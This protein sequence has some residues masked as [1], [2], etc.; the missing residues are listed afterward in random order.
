MRSE[1]EI[2]QKVDGLIAAEIR[3][4]RSERLSKGH[5]NCAFNTR[6]R[7]NKVGPTGF[8]QNKEVLKGLKT[9]VFV[10]NDDTTSSACKCFANKNTQESVDKEFREVLETPSLC[11]EKYPKLAMLLWVIQRLQPRSRWKRLRGCIGDMFSTF[12]VV[13]LFRWW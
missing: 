3:K 4:R 13:F 9:N 10:C 8:C 7:V 11:G 2:R 12:R 6:L 1:S 5:K